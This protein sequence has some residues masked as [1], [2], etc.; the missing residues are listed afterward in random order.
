MSVK[1]GAHLD[2]HDAIAQAKAIG[3]DAVQ[4]F[5]GDPQGW[6]GPEFSYPGG[7][8]ALKDDAAAAGL[9]LY[10][11]APYGINV[12]STNNRIRIPSRKLLQQFVAGA[13]LIG[14]KGVIVHGGHVSAKDD[15]G[16]GFDNWRKAIDSLESEVPVLIENTAGGDFAMARKLERIEQLWAAVQASNGA[17]NVGFTLDTCHA[18]AGGIDL[19]TAV[20]DI[21]AITGRIDLIH[22]NDSRDPAGSGADRHAHFGDGQ[23]PPELLTGVIAAAGAPVICETHG[24]MGPDIAWLRER[25]S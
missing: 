21:R 12:A 5:L 9:D 7:A 16:V 6:K 2:Q 4:V 3:A 11:H 14:A 23:I 22:A 10:V 25:L 1:I 24:D 18:W 19:A 17:A 15:P 20:A 8:D 13:A